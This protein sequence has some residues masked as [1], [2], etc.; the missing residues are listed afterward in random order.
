M[1]AYWLI[2][3]LWLFCNLEGNLFYIYLF[4]F[5]SVE[6]QLGS[7]VVAQASQVALVVNNLPVNAGDI[8]GASSIPGSGRSPGGGH[9]NSLQYYCLKNSMNRG[10]WWAIVRSVTKSRKRLKRLST[11]MQDVQHLAYFRQGCM[12]APFY[13]CFLESL[14]GGKPFSIHTSIYNRCQKL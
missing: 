12:H 1:S 3:I 10:A 9:G 6:S 4:D 11:H 13:L 14:G 8:R 5:D 2:L 7:F